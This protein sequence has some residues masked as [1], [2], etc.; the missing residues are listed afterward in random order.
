MFGYLK[1]DSVGLAIISEFFTFSLTIQ[2]LLSFFCDKA[3]E[4][5]FKWSLYT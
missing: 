3:Y 1:L 2:I 5:I 4:Y